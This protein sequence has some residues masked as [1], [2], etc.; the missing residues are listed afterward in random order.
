MNDTVT[1]YGYHYSVYTR[2]ACLVLT[3]KQVPFER[4]EVDPFGFLPEGYER[5]HPFGRVPV[6]RHGSFDL[7]ETGAITRYVDRTFGGP[8]LQPSTTAALARMDQVIG[9]V[10]SYAYVPLV[11]QVFSHAVFRPLMGEQA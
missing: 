7:Y 8:S 3:H 1:L 5:L 2:I 11:R 10:D 4:A 6:L 9:L